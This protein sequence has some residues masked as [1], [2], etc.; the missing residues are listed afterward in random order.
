MTTQE[1]INRH[2]QLGTKISGKKILISAMVDMPLRTVLF[3]MQRLVGN[4]GPHQESRVH[5][6]YELEAMAPMVYN[7]AEALLPVFKYHLTKCRLGELR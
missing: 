7:W 1:L 5:M 3:I 6:I 2:S 4:Q